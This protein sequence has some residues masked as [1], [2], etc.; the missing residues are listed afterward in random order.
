MWFFRVFSFCLS[1][2]LPEIG[3]HTRAGKIGQHPS[4]FGVPPLS[5]L[6]LPCHGDAFAASLAAAFAI[7]PVPFSTT[8][9]SNSLCS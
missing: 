3:L 7:S 4:P 9:V 8:T 1:A 5:G 6:T 2:F